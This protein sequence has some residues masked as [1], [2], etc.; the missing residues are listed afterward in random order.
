MAMNW[1]PE[2]KVAVDGFAM[3][4]LLVALP[5]ALALSWAT[6]K[7][8]RYSVNKAMRLSAGDVIPVATHEAGATDPRPAPLVLKFLDQSEG[9]VRSNSTSHHQRSNSA[10]RRL[11][12]IYA[13]AGAVHAAVITALWL[14]FNK[15]EFLPGRFSAMWLVYAWPVIPVLALTAIGKRK[16]KLL[17]IATYFIG[18]LALDTW[19]QASGHL[20]GPRGQILLLWAIEMA[21]PTVLLW[22]LGNRAL[23]CVGLIGL[24]VAI[25]LTVTWFA[26]FQM[27]GCL[28]LSTRSTILLDWFVPIRLSI[29]FAALVAIWLL[30]RYMA[31]RLWQ[32]QTSDLMFTID[33]WWLLI[34]LVEMLLFI[35][36]MQAA[37]VSVLL[38][39]VAYKIVV[40]IGLR[41][42]RAQATDERPPTLLLLRVF[43]HAR[44][45]ERLM[46][47]IGLRWRYV[48]PINLIAGTDIATSFLE[49]DELVQF[50]G[51]HLGDAYVANSSTL[52]AK[53]QRASRGASAD[54]RHGVNDFFCR[55]NTWRACVDALATSSDAVLMDLR[56]FSAANR[57]CE[58]ELGL[59][60]E[61]VALEKITFLVDST[62]DVAHLEKVLAAMWQQ[63]G[64]RGVNAA[65]TQPVLHL[66]R[67]EKHGAGLVD[68]LLDH[69]FGLA[70]GERKLTQGG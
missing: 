65:A 38:A 51:G 28:M 16:T 2:C 11:S 62:T 57:G 32:A 67:S 21:P 45:T 5:L 13:L 43:G 27:L 6:L 49:P 56:S 33:S 68:N 54:G 60:L 55:D 25:A 15:F 17:I 12:A 69:L 63:H 31:R 39:F 3:F 26:S 36:G 30:L 41:W 70:Q 64:P 9:E 61:H 24:L 52:S 4:S 40:V 22:L 18:L 7:L 10:L 42:S 37:A 44:R 59:L 53:L 35:S 8:Y 46:D 34:T 1:V 14:Y 29:V 19:M 48:G 23:R 47:E 20:V 58:F 50:L 66:F